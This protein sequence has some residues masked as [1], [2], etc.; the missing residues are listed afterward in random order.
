[1][2]QLVAWTVT[3]TLVAIMTVS[4]LDVRSQVAARAVS[5]EPIDAIIDAFRTHQVVALGEGAH[6]NVPGH[7]FRL[8][9][10]R[11]PRFAAT[12]N[13][14]VVEFGSA[15]Y[16]KLIDRYTLG[17]SVPPEELRHVWE[18]TT[19]PN[20]AWDKPIYAEFFRA[21]REINSALPEA[22]RI[23]VLLGD[24]P[25]DWDAVKSPGDYSTW[26]IQRDRFPADL[27][28]REVIAKGRRGLLI[29]G[30]GHYQ[31]RDERPPRSLGGFL[32]AGGA[33][34]FFITTAFQD[35]THAQPDIMTWPTPRLALLRGRAIGALP[36]EFFFGPKPP[37]A[38]WT[39]HARI[40][41]HY[42][43]ILYMGP[44][45][46][47]SFSPHTYPRCAEP[48]YVEMR[49]RRMTI[50]TA[51]PPSATSIAARLKQDCVAR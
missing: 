21:V 46:S 47:L 49:V 44:P 24:P 31:A 12:V 25:I 7:L 28:Q 40:E 6:G 2:S 27:T 45:A 51:T 8:A 35:L 14:V 38:Y 41:D 9:L 43:A 5:L 10:L 34:P 18:D 19:G 29:Y 16:Q 13:D 20:A 32:D 1:M 39:S 42:D 4:S 23:R 22:R 36:Y 11:D 37:G 17:G 33:T 50:A 48:S 26:A 3:A 15:R 30:D